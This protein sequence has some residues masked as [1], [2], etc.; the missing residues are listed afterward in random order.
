MSSDKLS[1]FSCSFHSDSADAP[2]PFS[3]V[4]E[5]SSL[6]AGLKPAQV[7]VEAPLLQPALLCFHRPALSPLGWT[8]S[9]ISKFWG[10]KFSSSIWPLFE[11]T[12]TRTEPQLSHTSV[13]RPWE[14]GLTFSCWPVEGNS[15]A[16]PWAGGGR[17]GWPV[18]STQR[19]L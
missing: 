1:S 7:A 17:P 18:A 3:R 11:V 5:L 4:L 8:Q 16:P 6:P 12:Q 9:L 15:H 10:Q 14:R 13:L 19:N 2:A